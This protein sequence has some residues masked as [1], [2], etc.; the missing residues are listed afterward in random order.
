MRSGENIVASFMTE[1]GSTNIPV[2]TGQGALYRPFVGNRE[3]GGDGRKATLET[4]WD[5]FINNVP[6]PDY[7]LAQNPNADEII[8]QHPDVHASMRLRELSVA[9]M[10][11][12][13]EPS[14]RGDIDHDAAQKVA[15]Y[16][17]GVFSTLPNIQD[18]YRIMQGAV[19][20]GGQGLEFVWGNRDGAL[21]PTKYYPVHKTR[22]VFD[23]LG[24]MALLTRQQPVWGAYL[25]SNPTEFKSKG[26]QAWYAPNGR[27]V[28]HKYMSEGGS[29]ER[30][31]AEGFVYWG[32]GEN[33]NLWN[34][35]SFDNF[36]VRFRMKWLERFGMPLTLIYYPD[37]DPGA[38]E[39]LRQIATS[40]REDTVASVPHRA[41]E[42]KDS[43]YSVDYQQPTMQGNDAFARFTEDYVRSRIEKII[44]GGA[45]LLQ[46]GPNGSY[47][48]AVDQRDAGAEIIF[49]FDANNI[50]ETLNTQLIP[51]I[52]RA[53]WPEIPDEYLPVHQMAPKQPVDRNGE[54]DTLTKLAT[55]VP[56]RKDDFYEAAGVDKPEKETD[57]EEMVYLGNSG[58]MMSGMDGFP[59]P[60]MGGAGEA[61]QPG[62]EPVPPIGQEPQEQGAGMK[63]EPQEQ[64][65]G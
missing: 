63:T 49:K 33:S 16:V 34:L 1:G 60:I 40:I 30:P 50:S 48:A 36:V 64:G 25:Q 44:L 38:A 42:P 56:V 47:G 65:N 19:L 10:P 43:Y 32:R 7:A 5:F 21:V 45:N 22:F 31:A 28:Y 6:D 24:S 52:A 59:P 62:G 61:G 4:L 18:M 55:V 35:V 12:H 11:W 37:T 51:H 2:D 9:S 54:L 20:L 23:R 15:D 53:K 58:E 57:P 29:W 41:G 39:K 3:V 8:R 17:Q 26:E 46:L 13:I 27:F 14:Q